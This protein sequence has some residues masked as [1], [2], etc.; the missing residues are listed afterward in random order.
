MRIL[1]LTAYFPP[2]TGSASHLFYE[3]GKSLLKSGHEVKV[4]TSIPGY[5]PSGDVSKYKHKLFMNEKLDGLDTLRIAAPKFPRHI[6]LTRGI[7]QFYLAF[8]FFL[9]L[10]FMKKV[11][12]ILIYSPPLT[13]GLTGW[14]VSRLKRIPVVLNVQD[15]FPQS[16]IDLGVLRNKILIKIFYCLEKFIYGK[17]DLVSVHSLG[18]KEYILSKGMKKEGCS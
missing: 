17:M 13:L 8:V 1:L 18:N 15:L 4:V 7:W 3:L 6:P 16:A 10:F 5:F 11:D 12:V 14:A 9:S 2:D